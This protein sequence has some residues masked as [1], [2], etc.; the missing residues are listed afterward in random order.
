MPINICRD[1]VPNDGEVAWLCH[2]EWELPSQI[3]AL[4]AWLSDNK[5]SLDA[6][7]HSA[8]IG[9]SVRPDACGGGAVLE[10]EFLLSLAEAKISIFLSEYPNDWNEWA[11]RPES[12]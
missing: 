10:P 4:K 3:E 2:D 11:N 1:G 7:P 9:F 12:L 6:V 5:D 8:D